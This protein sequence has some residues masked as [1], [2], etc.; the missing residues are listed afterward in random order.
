MIWTSRL[1]ADELFLK[2]THI[3][4]KLLAS[5]DVTFTASL[6]FCAGVSRQLSPLKIQDAASRGGRAA[7]LSLRVSMASAPLDSQCRL[8]SFYC[9]WFYMSG[10]LHYLPD[11]NHV[12][13]VKH[14]LLQTH[15]KPTFCYFLHCLSKKKQQMRGYVKE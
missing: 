12:S 1:Q 5:A 14:D 7:R 4:S 6:I 10:C 13:D 11:G 9:C 2:L 15:F 3:Y 8:T